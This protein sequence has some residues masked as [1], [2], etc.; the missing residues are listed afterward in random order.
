MAEEENVRRS[1]NPRL[2]LEAILCRLAW[3][4]PMIPIDEVLSRMEGL[5]RRL[6]GGGAPPGGVAGGETPRPESRRGAAGGN[7][8]ANRGTQADPAAVDARAKKND[9]HAAGTGGSPPSPAESAPPANGTAPTGRVAEERGGY[10]SEGAAP[11][12]GGWEA[13]KAFVKRQDPILCSKIEMGKCLACGEGLL[14]IGF[15][16]DSSNKDHLFLGDVKEKER[17][18]AELG[19]RFFRREV[20]L[21]IE[22]LPFDTA[23]GPNGANGPK[24]GNGNGRA[25][26]N[27][28]LQEIRREA[29]SHPFVLKV[30]DVFPRAEVRD[31]RL[32]EVAATETA[33]APPVTPPDADLLPSETAPPADDETDQD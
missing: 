6:G 29:L 15:E 4:E 24:S 23:G 5:E 3:L 1:Q 27:H 33:A 9:T 18:L 11:P 28:R 19:R 32:R 22:T 20:T 8:P 17:E 16:K 10:G 21:A 30:L 13:F 26:K 12:E 31:V 25:A 14:K 2:N 7:A